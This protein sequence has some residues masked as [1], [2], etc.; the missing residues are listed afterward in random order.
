LKIAILGWARLSAQE[1]EGS[2]YN[3]AASELAS[4]L[5]AK[6]H[7]VAYLR[8]GMDY[9]VVRP[10]H[11]RASETWH[12]VECFELVN[13]PN[14]SPAG[15]NFRNMEIEIACPP[16]VRLVLSWLDRIEADVVHVHSL[17][18]YSLDLIGAVRDTGRPVV[19]TPHNYWFVCPQVDL[20]YQERALCF[21][22][23]GGLRCA[24][25]IQCPPPATAR[26]RRA[27]WQSLERK[28]G[29]FGAHFV[30]RAALKVR[31][32]L[33]P[34]AP[35][36]ALPQPPLPPTHLREP[37]T[38]RFDGFALDPQSQR[39]GTVDH[40]LWLH[41]GEEPERLAPARFDE[42]ERF[43]AATH[44]RVLNGA[45]GERRAAGVAAL[46]RASL[47]VPPSR[48]LRDVHKTMGVDPERMRVLRLG[49]PHLD[50]LNR[51]ARLS[52][53]YDVRPWE[54]E[55][56][57]RPLRFGFFGTTR[58]SKGLRVLIDA[59]PLL[60]PAARRRCQFLVRASG[61]D[62]PFRK[63]VSRFPE[64]QFAGGYDL[65]QRI[66]SWG[67]YDV[68]ILTHVWFENSPIVLLEHL[69]AGKFA[70][71]PSLGGP[72]EWITHGVN[73]LLYAGGHPEALA[74]CIEDLVDGTVPIPS[75][76]EVHESTKLTSFPE[77]VA[78]VE[79]LY[80]EFLGQ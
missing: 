28:A 39:E 74:E 25:C 34:S 37:H 18:G 1:R 31:A 67:E 41:P 51:R 69:H 45:Y 65:I 76:R 15:H 32:R 14:L 9:G 47:V 2:G 12:G 73:G 16:Q 58:N 71:S 36:P 80:Q 6:G 7:R 72:P 75:P 11:V 5:C 61:W 70:V 42:N 52:P 48:F 8:S 62:W 49:T 33:R 44:H 20:L 55:Q 17:E 50:R 59:I 4:G 63:M 54:P 79:A 46:N 23:E 24:T 60:S 68:G 22:Y 38:D 13:S 27:I 3:L 19:V 56:A 64:V 43:L 77:H 35:G 78:E 10:P 29:V 66:G 30:H 26:R 57:R 40:G 53:F 21:D